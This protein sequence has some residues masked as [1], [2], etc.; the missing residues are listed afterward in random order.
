VDCKSECHPKGSTGA[1]MQN[2]GGISV[3]V[4]MDGT[5]LRLQVDGIVVALLCMT[6]AYDVDVD[7]VDADE[8]RIS[9]YSQTFL[10]GIMNI[11]GV[12]EES[13]HRMSNGRIASQTHNHRIVHVRMLSLVEEGENLDFIICGQQQD[14]KWQGKTLQSDTNDFLAD[15][16]D[17]YNRFGF[18][19]ANLST[20]SVEEAVV[21]H[22]ERSMRSIR[23][24]I[25][26]VK[27]NERAIFGVEWTLKHAAGAS[28]ASS[29][30]ASHALR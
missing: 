14:I 25:S 4:V 12:S 7:D 29:G 18:P 24:L 2:D 30:G 21:M 16:A 11:H 27:G 10:D 19:F 6:S 5:K 26:F 1:A 9:E 20:L 23:T 8:V 15:P 28:G 3:A 13:W 22:V 17:F